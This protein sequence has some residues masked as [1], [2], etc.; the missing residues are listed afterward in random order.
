MQFATSV[1]GA[2]QRHLE[3]VVELLPGADSGLVGDWL[4]Q[5]GLATA[6]LM[7][8][9]LATGSAAAMRAAFG[10]EEAPAV[11]EA[12]RAHVRSVAIVPP[13]RLHASE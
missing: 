6:A 9:L 10:S 5:R 7:V 12:L 8:G 13:R 4:A 11:P 3:A 1:M 2:E